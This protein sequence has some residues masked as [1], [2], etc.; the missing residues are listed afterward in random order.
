MQCPRC[1]QDN[2]SHAK[3]CLACGAPVKPARD[4]ALE[5]SY[6][7]LQRSLSETLARERATGEILRVI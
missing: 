3:F 5:P 6:P 2:P 7:E 4:D 1:Q